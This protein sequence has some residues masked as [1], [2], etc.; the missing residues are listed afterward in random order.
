MNYL[1]QRAK[2]NLLSLIFSPIRRHS[3]NISKSHHPEKELVLFASNHLGNQLPTLYSN[4]SLQFNCTLCINYI[5]KINT[6]CFLKCASLEFALLTPHSLRFQPSTHPTTSRAANQRSNS[7][8]DTRAANCTRITT[9][10][11]PPPSSNFSTP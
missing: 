9:P 11:S 10:I 4:N 7:P 6:A 5:N 2:L 1:L 3:T 8:S